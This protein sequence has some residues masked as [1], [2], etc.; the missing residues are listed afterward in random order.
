MIGPSPEIGGGDLSSHTRCAPS[1]AAKL[2]VPVLADG[3]PLWRTS[4][5]LT[6]HGMTARTDLRLA[7]LNRTP[8][9]LA[10]D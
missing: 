4:Q 6:R 5:A 2:K 3:R 9:G 8:H 7:E 1:H 10:D